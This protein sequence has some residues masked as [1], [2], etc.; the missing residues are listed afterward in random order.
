MKNLPTNPP[1]H[2]NNTPPV[3]GKTLGELATPQEIKEMTDLIEQN[4]RI[5]EASEQLNPYEIAEEEKK[6][7]RIKAISVEK[8]IHTPYDEL[9]LFTIARVNELIQHHNQEHHE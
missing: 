9:L 2:F 3:K 5:E 6:K 1:P 8:C 4:K 7:R